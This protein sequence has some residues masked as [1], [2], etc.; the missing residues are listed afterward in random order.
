MHHLSIVAEPEPEVQVQKT[1]L[2]REENIAEPVVSEHIEIEHVVKNQIVS[3]P[4]PVREEGDTVIVPVVKQVL[5]I[6]KD[7]VLTEEIHL[8]RRRVETRV[9]EPVRLQYEQ[10]EIRE[11]RRGKLGGRVPAFVGKL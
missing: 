7:W 8:K 2:E 10:V 1:L 4:L 6:E 3:G 5:R 9:E 11:P